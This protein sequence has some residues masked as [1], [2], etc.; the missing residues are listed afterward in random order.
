M[1][2]RR[3]GYTKIV[4]ELKAGTPTNFAIGSDDELRSVTRA[5]QKA[6]QLLFIIGPRLLLLSLI[7]LKIRYTRFPV[8]GH[9]GSC[10]LVANLLVS[11]RCNG[12]W[13]TTRHNR[14]NGLFTR[15]NLLQT[16]CRPYNM[17]MFMLR[18]CYGEVINLLRT[19]YR[20]TGVMDFG[21]YWAAM[22]ILRHNRSVSTGRCTIL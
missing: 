5:A 20:E 2:Q 8:D 3:H 22:A 18:T 11:S 9:R 19:C 10:Q 15:P 12:I 6:A 17:F 16:C 1:H 14:H 4:L 13:E 7:I 21:R